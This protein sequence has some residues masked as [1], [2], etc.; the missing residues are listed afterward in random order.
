MFQLVYSNLCKIVR[1]AF[2]TRFTE[3]AALAPQ[4]GHFF[5]ILGCSWGTPVW[6]WMQLDALG[7][8]LAASWFLLGVSLALLDASCM[9]LGLSWVPLGWL[10]GDVGSLLGDSVALLGS[11]WMTLGLPC[12]LLGVVL[13]VFWVPLSGQVRPSWVVDGFGNDIC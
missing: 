5:D 6:S 1:V 2:H 7:W 4:E 3:V 9:P 10:L 8:L 11:S 12:V 13:G